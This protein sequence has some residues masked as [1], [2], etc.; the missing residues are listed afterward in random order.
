[1]S[2]SN[3]L[4][5]GMDVHKD[6]VMIA[7]L[8]EHAKEPTRVERLSNEERKLRRFFDRLGRE[9]T[10]CACYEASG[11]GYVLQRSLAAWGHH[12]DICAPSLTPTRRGERRKHDRRDAISLAELYRA[13]QL[14]LIRIPK[15]AEERVRDVVRCRET[16]NREALKSRHYIL[17]FLRRRGLIY[18]EGKHWTRKHFAWLRSLLRDGV[19]A[20]EDAV[21]FGEYLALLEY[22]LARRDE[23]DRR[24]EELAL[25]PAR[26][27]AVERIRCFRGL[28][29]HA[30]MVLS[31]EIVDFRRF[32]SPRQ[33]MA[34]LGLVPSEHS[35][36][37]RE[38]RGS[39][40]KAGN[41]HCRHVLVQAAWSYRHR[42][43]VGAAH[44][45]RQQGQAPEVIAHAW[46]AQHRLYKLYH[47]VAARRG[48]QVAAVA[49]ARELVGF[50][51]AVMRDLE[52]E[53]GAADRKAA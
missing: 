20:G 47:R 22:K 26:R 15:E 14:V 37:E 39:I 40:T 30:A 33:L 23:L 7:V 24:I 19:M 45:K 46:K 6:S 38:R 35:S 12:C 27:A 4:F 42:P 44:K 16:L 50:I 31:T 49:V 41:T 9:G 48:P 32:V 10:V 52:T 2:K 21:V 5:V 13:G 28:D 11:A 36:G 18:R 53:V 8:P 34:Y 51:W 17:K 3:L 29:T 1:M 43:A 25:E